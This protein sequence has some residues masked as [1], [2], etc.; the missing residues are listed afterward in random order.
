MHTVR[1]VASILRQLTRIA[2]FIFLAT[3]VYSGALLLLSQHTSI[4]GL[5]IRFDQNGTYIIFYPFTKQPFLIGELTT[6]YQL[7]STTVVALYGVFLLLLSS[8][9]NVFS[10][11]RLFTAA[12]VKVLI[13]FYWFNILAPGIF[14]LTLLFLGEDVS[15]AIMI[16]FLHTMLSVFIFFMAAIFKQGLLL[17]E[18]QDL[19][20]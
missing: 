4:S 17:Q 7:F 16:V 15:D 12:G 18:E 5:P 1:K 13:A 6:A 20:L 10:K 2:A 9:F 14:L 3:A 19:I 11:P 8:V